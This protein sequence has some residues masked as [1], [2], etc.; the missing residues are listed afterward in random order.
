MGDYLIRI[1]AWIPESR[2]V[3]CLAAVDST[4]QSLGL[5]SR[6]EPV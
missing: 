6:A 3:T 2:A 1:E 5:S 4:A